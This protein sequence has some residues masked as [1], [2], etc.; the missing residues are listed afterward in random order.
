MGM[1]EAMVP[2]GSKLVGQTVLE[3]RVRRDYG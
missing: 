1:V 2:A 3:A